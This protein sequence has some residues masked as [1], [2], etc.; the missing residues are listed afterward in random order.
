[1]HS[2]AQ[3]T[4]N[5]TLS[6]TALSKARA[7]CANGGE[8]PGAASTRLPVL[9]SIEESDLAG[10]SANVISKESPTRDCVALILSGCRVN[11]RGQPL[12]AWYADSLCNSS[13]AVKPYPTRLTGAAGVAACVAAGTL[14]AQAVGRGA[15][16]GVAD[17]AL[18]HGDIALPLI[19]TLLTVQEEQGMQGQHRKARVDSNAAAVGKYASEQNT[20]VQVSWPSG[21]A[22]WLDGWMDWMIHNLRKH[23]RWA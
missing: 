23:L 12:A 22:D 16:D 2:R 4:V 13:W 14:A 21:W 18:Q 6:L 11:Q 3:Q 5:V 1:M 19:S 9:A 7:V 8:A 10:H 20:A 17:C 15:I